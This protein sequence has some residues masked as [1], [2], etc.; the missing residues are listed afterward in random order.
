MKNL[1]KSAV[2]LA[3]AAL[4]AFGGIN[5]FAAET[6]VEVDSL[7][8]ETPEIVNFSA[9]DQPV[10]INNTLYVPSRAMADAMGMRTEWDQESLTAKLIVSAD[11][12]SS[13]PIER[14]AYKIS[15]SGADTAGLSAVPEDITLELTADSA[16]AAVKFGYIDAS[17]TRIELG[18][19][20]ELDG[21]VKLMGGGTLMFPLRSVIESFYLEL[22]WE[23]E[24][25]TA[26]VTIPDVAVIP[27]GLVRIT[28]DTNL[29]I[30]GNTAEASGAENSNMVYLGTFRISHYAP[31][32]ESNG[33]WGNATAWAGA[34][35]PGRTIAV[36]K[37]VIE[38]L[39]WVYIDGYGYRCA[40]DCG[41]AIVGNKIDV[42]VASY[43]E[44]MRLGV[45]YK[46]VYLCAE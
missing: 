21:K 7:A 43:A 3:A 40:E 4:T 15:Q 44:A 30:A 2:V 23:Q 12:D 14:Y 32:A 19:T 26:S 46:D 5:V 39:S 34:I 1:R 38:P 18:K 8:Y 9:D 45:V 10:E 6:V 11:S 29:N 41:G 20:T 37:D 25:R 16:N 35:T 22:S 28:A 24:S 17:G 36:D 27:D 31:G 13:K 42:A 33:A